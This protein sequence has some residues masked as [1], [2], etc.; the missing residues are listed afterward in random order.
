MTIQGKYFDAKLFAG[1]YDLSG[2]SN[3]IQLAHNAAMLDASTMGVDCKVNMAGIKDSRIDAAGFM[4]TPSATDLTDA[5]LFGNVGL[6]NIPV[7]FMPTNTPIEGSIAYFMSAAQPEYGVGAAHG[8]L[9]PYKFSA[10]N[11]KTLSYPLVRGFVLE[12]GTTARVATGAGTGFV[13][14]AASASQYIYACLHVF[15]AVAGNTL[16]VIVEADADGNFAA[17][18]ATKFT[19]A[20][21][22]GIT[23]QFIARVAGAEAKTYYRVSWTIGGATPSFK[24]A[25]VV[26]II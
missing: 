26:G 14:G 20:Q 24:F 18:A 23:S 11:G 17:G 6:D 7:T 13:V 21:A 22:T 1:A 25:C 2:V 16:D 10:V 8:A 12:P 4:L 9:A 19:F 3:T 15:S 5:T